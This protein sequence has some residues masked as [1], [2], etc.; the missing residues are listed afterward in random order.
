MKMYVAISWDEDVC[1]EDKGNVIWRVAWW[2]SVT[3]R[4]ED[5][6][7]EDKGDAIWGV[8]WWWS[9][10]QRDAYVYG[11]EILITMTNACMYG[12]CMKV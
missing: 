2:W 1:G 3:Q 7:G 4:D 12:R 11:D 8:A 6:Y 5:V 10:T 9:T